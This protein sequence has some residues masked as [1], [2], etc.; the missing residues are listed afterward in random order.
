[1]IDVV[2]VGAPAGM[3]RLLSRKLDADQEI[4]I[5]SAVADARTARDAVIGLKP[6]VVVLDLDLSGISGLAFLKQLLR[7][8]PLPVVLLSS[9]GE[10][11]STRVQRALELGAVDVFTLSGD[12]GESALRIPVLAAMIKAASQCRL[13]LGRIRKAVAKTSKSATPLLGQNTSVVAVGS[14]TGGTEA[15]NDILSQLPETTPGLLIVQHM[16]A[17]FTAALARRLDKSSAME[18]REARDGDCPRQGLALISPGDRHMRVER[19]GHDLR[20]RLDEGPP[21]NRHRPSVDVLFHSVAQVY[22]KKSTGVILTGMGADGAEGLLA[23]RREGARTIAQ[24]EASSVIFG[25]PRQAIELG[26]AEDVVSLQKI[27]ASLLMASI[28]R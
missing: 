23:M 24:D 15:L 1:M 26:A 22:G 20:V 2:V 4:R 3:R 9:P 14:S 18:V 13:D 12:P 11:K 21:V 16:P 8:Q 19:Q 7:H 28:S 10:L 5:L 25:M 6:D 27:P 17:E